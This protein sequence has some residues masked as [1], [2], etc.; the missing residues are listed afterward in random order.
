MKK[1]FQYLLVATA[2]IALSACSD[3]KEG[4]KV[5]DK[6][7][8]NINVIAQANPLAS[9]DVETKTYLGTYDEVPN[10]VL[11]GTDEYMKLGVTY[12]SGDEE[13]TKFATSSEANANGLPQATFA[14]SISFGDATPDET[15]TYTYHGLYPASAAVASN[16]T[17]A[18]NYK[19]NLPAT[20]NATA[21]SYD[22]AA[23]IMVAKPE[24]FD[25]VQTEW[26]ASYRRATALNKVTLKNLPAA[27]Q[28]AGIKRVEI[29]VTVND[30]N[31]YLA[32]S[33][34]IDLTTGESGDI[35][36][37][38]GR[39]NTVAVKFAN[40]LTG[41][42]NVDVWFTS[43]GVE[44]EEGDAVTVAVYAGDKT[45]LR[46]IT[47]GSGKSISFKEGYLNTLGVNMGGSDVI[48]SDNT[49]F[50]EGQYVIVALDGSN[51]LYALKAQKESGKQRLLAVGYDY[52][53]ESYSGDEDIIWNI[54][55][56]GD[57]YIFENS[58]QYLG[59]KGSNNES[60]WLEP[61]EEWTEDNYLLDITPQE[62]EGQYYV[63][64]NSNP[65]RYLSRNSSFFAFYGNTNQKAD[66][67]FVPATIDTRAEV[68]LSFAAQ[69]INRTTATAEGFN[70]QVAT[71]TSGSDNVEGLEI[72]YSWDGESDF[73]SL[74]EETGV[75]S[76]SG[77]PGTAV[78]TATFEGDDDYR[79]TTAT[80]RINV[81][82]ETGPQYELVS[83]VDEVVAGDYIITWDNTY[84][85]PSGSESDKNPA[86]GEGITVVSNKITNTVTDDMIWTFT[87]N[88]TNGFTISDGTNILH[89]TNAA[90]GI[91]INT[92]STRKWTVSVNN[93]Y[94][95]LLHGDDGGSRYL[96]VYGTSSWRYYTAGNDYKGTLRL[97]KLV[98]NREEAGMSWSA[99]T[100]SATIYDTH[101]AFT[102]P[103]LTL[104]NAHDVTFNSTAPAVATIDDAGDIE[105]LA[106]G[107]TTIQAIFGGDANYKSA[108]VEYTLTVTD[109]RT[110]AA[111]TIADVLAGG[112][113]TY[114]LAN[115]LVYAVNG[116]NVIVGDASG[117]M[118]LYMTNTL[119]VGDNISIADAVTTVYQ[120]I[121]EITAGTITVNSS[122]NA[123]DH[124]TPIDL[125]DATAASSTHTTFS[126]TGNHSAVYVSMTGEQS[127]QNV[128]G[129]NPNTTL[130]LNASN[131][132]TSGRTVNVT[133]YVYSW[134]SNYNNY[135]FQAVSINIDET[136]PY[137]SVSPGAYTWGA[138]E[139]DL[140][141][142]TVTVNNNE[143]FTV[144]IKSGEYN[145]WNITST[146]GTKLS[147]KPK[148]ANT[149]TTEDK[150]LVLR[151]YHSGAYQDVTCTQY[152]ASAGNPVDVLTNAN[153]I[154]ASSSTYTEWLVGS[155]STNSGAA[156][157]GQSAGTNNTIQ[158]R[159]NNSNS[160]VVTTV[161]GGKARKVVVTWNS[162]TQSGRTLNVYGKSS[163]Y[164]A[165]T[166]LYNANAQGTLLGTIVN[167][168]STELIITGDYEF[169]GFRSSSSA[170]YLDKVE[171][172]WEN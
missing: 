19:V 96:A 138:S 38:G 30:G 132:A 102:A 101:V 33:R 127:G 53:L 44:L 81:I 99:S 170:M 161:S 66:L 28:E 61:G 47:L 155:L 51:P 130:H 90:Q 5:N 11:W 124:G 153:T 149:S 131:E 24:T 89:S 103:E 134:S 45:Y 42:A 78:V 105:I 79:P 145:D 172:T 121:L 43:W 129:S 69:E 109:E 143:G 147:V 40:H 100:A 152:K 120:T 112:A 55:K 35:Y 117:K 107:T 171:I 73:G 168:N 86:V 3:V 70:G 15:S 144:D 20:Q 97:Y 50:E 169:I 23:Y 67:A 63:T 163:A 62:T 123:V 166:D 72:T 80:Y 83:S 162:A 148:A 106:E 110:P 68:T 29:A 139:T 116:N 128:T 56:S 31:T 37:G 71:A 22:P 60:Y 165:P 125:N 146:G 87:G 64:L 159:S 34:H 126:A 59:Y 115:L 74:N 88:N 7:A 9:D 94:G 41:S 25:E 167:G 133:G 137:I 164:S 18:A 32:G 92:T 57:S 75:V 150:V 49:E 12:L 85:L 21:A 136:V 158:L 2:A 156:Y 84:Y 65:S 36:T 77:E 91:S 58:G 93:N 46:I 8:I 118:L 39:T 141:Q 160:G 151:V 135:N 16:N 14:F 82:S 52:G 142:F 54:T 27:V 48:V 111:T 154:N 26:L 17:N 13:K 119:A 4:G 98:D 122:G 104:G 76:L 1:I 6:N 10:T 140:K 157:S 114:Q 95:M 113:G 108:T